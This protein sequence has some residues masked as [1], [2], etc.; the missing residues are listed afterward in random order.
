MLH[1]WRAKRNKKG[2]TLIE[3]ML[4]LLITTVVIGAVYGSFRAGLSTWKKS[5]VKTTVYQNVRITLDQ[6][7]RE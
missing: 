6:M 4:A 5:D 3:L 1:T 2:I 7:A